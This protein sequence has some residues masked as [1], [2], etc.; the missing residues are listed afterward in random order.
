MTQRPSGEPR[1]LASPSLSALA[2]AAP[3]R[4]KEEKDNHRIISEQG[5]EDHELNATDG[6]VSRNRRAHA[7]NHTLVNQLPG[8][9]ITSRETTSRRVTPRKPL[10]QIRG[11]PSF[12]HRIPIQTIDYVVEEV[13]LGQLLGKM[14]LE[15]S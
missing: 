10:L 13:P 3:Q 5:G 8:M 15:C 12:F 1:L 4:V 7:S 14:Q 11:T 2:A 9:D 6:R